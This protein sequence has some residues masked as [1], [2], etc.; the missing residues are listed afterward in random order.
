MAAECSRDV[1]R[2]EEMRHVLFREQ[3]LVQSKEWGLLAS[4]AG[5]R[6]PQQLRKC[7]ETN[8]FLEAV[9]EDLKAGET[10]GV[11]ATPSILVNDS[12]FRGSLSLSALQRHLPQAQRAQ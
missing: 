2:Y 9:R 4:A 1:G 12:L 3:A 5:V 7:V 10:V 6:N 11:E 8:R